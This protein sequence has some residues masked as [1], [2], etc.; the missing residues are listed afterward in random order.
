[1][2]L[3]PP[4]NDILASRAPE[5]VRRRCEG[6]AVTKHLLH[7]FPSFGLGGV[8]IRIASIVNFLGGACRH[9][10]MAL[11]GNFDSRVRID[12]GIQ[13]DYRRPEASRYLLWQNI[14]QNRRA[15]ADLAPDLLLTYNWGAIEW[16][17]ANGLRPLTRHIHFESG[18]GVEEADRLLMRRVI[19]RRLALWNTDLV[20]VPSLKLMRIATGQ[21]KQPSRKVK[22][23]PNGVDIDRFAAAHRAA[24][25]TDFAPSP[26]EIV[27]GTLAPL[28][29][30]KNVGRLIQAFAQLSSER[31][32]RLMIVGDGP[33]RPGLERLAQDLGVS[34]RTTFTGHL[35]E[36][37]GVLSWFDIF[38]LSSDTEQM[39]NSLL[40]AMAAGCAVAAVDVGDVKHMV[41]PDNR[42]LIVPKAESELSRALDRLTADTELRDR[43]GHA[44][45]AH[46]QEHYSAE[47]MYGAYSEILGL[48]P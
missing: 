44:N 30:E 7:V 29:A 24:P 32:L 40:Q 12:P 28:R 6:G 42:P 48:Q 43:L 31:S 21:W 33:E 4:Q 15:I 22:H 35:E 36:I 20:V 41:A 14:R 17:L 46:V 37:E 2:E 3:R 34:A 23:I 16:A 27:I 45:R 39:P 13:V 25:P 18:F 38:A 26:G 1:M 11:D 8:P 10:V 5:S 9:T 19:F 47:R